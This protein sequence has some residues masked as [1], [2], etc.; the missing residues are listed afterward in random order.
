MTTDTTLTDGVAPAPADDRASV[1]PLWL[2][3]M[4]WANALAVILMI[5]SGWRIYD[6]TNFLHFYTPVVTA[7]GV[8]WL[9]GI[10]APYTLGG[11]LGGAL[12]WHFAAMWI[13][14]INAVLYVVISFV[15]KRFVPQFL[16]VTIPGI[17]RDLK[18]AL[19]GHLS[20]ADLRHYNY[21]QRAA[22]LFAMA[23]IIVLVISGCAL[24]KSVQFAWA[25]VL[26]FGYEPARYIH[27]TA[28]VLLCGFIVVHVVMALLVP[29]TI[30]A[31]IW[32]R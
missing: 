29:K 11:W 14:L 26:T 31:M 17:F 24:W 7:H 5:M 6:A 27:F 1:H 22:Y 23:D 28:M 16:P 12:Q 3:L 20:H 4:H 13:L 32:G 2:R 10:A 15:T 19:T 30:K 18:A 8:Q 9:W 25:R 21:V